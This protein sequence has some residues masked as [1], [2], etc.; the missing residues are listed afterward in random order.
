MSEI[1]KEPQ[2]VISWDGWVCN[3][4][5]YVTIAA[6]Q[7]VSVGVWDTANHVTCPIPS[8]GGAWTGMECGQ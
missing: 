1:I 3:F 7:A 8:V 6:S 5:L 4:S 2:T